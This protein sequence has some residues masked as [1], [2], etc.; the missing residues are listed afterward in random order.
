MVSKVP[1]GVG[2]V[3]VGDIVAS[4]LFEWLEADAFACLHADPGSA[5]WCYSNHSTPPE[6][7]V[8]GEAGSK[9][10][11]VLATAKRNFL[12]PHT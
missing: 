11:V 12:R 9:S 10:C 7:N 8:R 1:S 4:E 6:T 3:E 2:S 5:S